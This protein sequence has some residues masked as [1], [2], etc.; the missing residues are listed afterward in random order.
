MRLIYLKWNLDDYKKTYTATY[1]FV[2]DYR[3]HRR[4]RHLDIMQFKT[5]INA[6]IPRIKTKDG[7]IESIKVPWASEGNTHTFLFEILIIDRLLA[8]KNQS[9]TAGMLRCGFNVVNRIIH[10]ASLQTLPAEYP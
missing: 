4:W 5:Y 1:E 9:K 7:K 10:A 8:T 3:D 6:K 2:H